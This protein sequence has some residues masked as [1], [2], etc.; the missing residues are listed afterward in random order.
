MPIIPGQDPNE[1]YD[2]VPMA[3][4]PRGRTVDGEQSRAT[5]YRSIIACRPGATWPNVTLPIRATA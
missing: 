4:H 3:E 5:E 2:V 1:A